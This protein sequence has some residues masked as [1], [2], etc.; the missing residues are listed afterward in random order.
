MKSLNYL[1]TVIMQI[2]Y[3]CKNHRKK[4][5]SQVK[6]ELKNP[7]LVQIL[8]KKFKNWTITRVSWKHLLLHFKIF[9]AAN[10]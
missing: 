10:C 7:N 6:R 2:F 8:E 4:N 5:L 1:L 3:I 9:I